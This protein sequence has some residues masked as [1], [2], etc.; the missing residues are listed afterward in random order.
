V[1]P[2]ASKPPAY[3]LYV[4]SVITSLFLLY[5]FAIRP[6]CSGR[7]SKYDPSGGVSGLP[8]GMMVLPVGGQQGK[9]GKKGKK[10][11]GGRDSV[12]VN[13]IVDPGMFG[14]GDRERDDRE[15]DPRADA[16]DYESDAYTI[17]GTYSN[18]RSSGGP[19]KRPRPRRSIF[20]S[21]AQENAW[22]EARSWLKKLL[23]IDIC[24][25]I[26]W[27]GIFV[28][29]LLGKRCPSGAFGGW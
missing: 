25:T 4:V 22:R 3:T 15:Y 11:D 14:G 5:L 6:Q 20:A 17:P 19:R 1:P 28:F 12:Q 7:R 16:D 26:V 24:G 18:S 13:L 8:G 21:L 9:K 29:I 27:A 10:S 2:P 23:L